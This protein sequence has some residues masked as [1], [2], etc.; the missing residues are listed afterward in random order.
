MSK[1]IFRD[2]LKQ[3]YFDEKGYVKIKLFEDAELS[4]LTS[5]ANEHLNSKRK[6]ID[7]A[8]SMNYYI[9]IF[10]QDNQHKKEANQLIGE[11]VSEKL[12]DILD[13][14][15]CFYSNYMIKYPGDD[16]LE[17]HQ[18]FNLVDESQFTGLNLWCPLVDAH[19]NNGGLFFIPGSN[20][21]E[22]L[23]RGPN[24]PFSFTSYHKAI[25]EKGQF[26]QVKKGECLIFDHRTIHYSS[27][28]TT[29]TIRFAIQSVLKP[30]ESDSLIYHYDETSGTVSAKS[31]TADFVIDHGF[32]SSEI[33]NLPTLHER[34]Y[35]NPKE[36]DS[37]K[38]VINEKVN[39]IFKNNDYEQKL[40][41]VGYLKLRLIDR[42]KVDQLKNLYRNQVKSKM[43]ANSK[44]GLYV[45]I[46]EF[47][48]EES[49]R[50]ESEA[51][52]LIKKELDELFMPYQT[53]LGG[54]LVKKPGKYT[55]T[56]PHQDW[57]FVEPE[58]FRSVTVWI[59]LM[60]IDIQGSTL[61]FAPNSMKYFDKP[62][63]TPVAILK[64]A[65]TGH[66]NELYQYLDF[67]RIEP[68]EAFVFDNRI[69]HAATPN[70]SNEDRIAYAITLTAP[71]ANL[72]QFIQVPAESEE[73][74]LVKLKVDKDFFH[75]Y[76]IEKADELYAENKL[77]E[78]YS[79][80]E[81]ISEKFEMTSPSVID[82]YIRE[83]NLKNNGLTIE[84]PSQEKEKHG[85]EKEKKVSWLKRIFR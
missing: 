3:K 47:G 57:T 56:Y 48:I 58:K 83:N 23:Y 35:V 84:Y 55:Y 44:Y 13:D 14:Y 85:I 74:K 71:Q 61:G 53:F 64:S 67:Q 59:A 65:T 2:H 24:I 6:V 80:I 60:P 51:E 36:I 79:A 12:T 77:P 54:F 72:I 81:E 15:E 34:K 22:N 17:A 10:D 5:F 28:N 21:I 63:G 30:I 52:E 46:E 9:S 25:A 33:A 8:E 11:L 1:V 7:F 73:R 27:S 29:Q 66:E 39:R 70:H 49:K 38:E 78:G 4:R 26:I 32:W 82:L 75:D 76:S 62:V 45:T 50:I 18:D 19:E 31:I 41:D 43:V 69:V 40:N 68:G 42:A 37:V 20:H 16:V